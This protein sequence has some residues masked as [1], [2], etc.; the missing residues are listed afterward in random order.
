M[1]YIAKLE[2]LMLFS[3]LLLFLIFTKGGHVYEIHPLLF[4]Y[5]KPRMLGKIKK[6]EVQNVRRHH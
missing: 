5:L 4:I 3:I 1:G 6:E 2:N